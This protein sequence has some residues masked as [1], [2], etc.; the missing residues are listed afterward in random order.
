M[1]RLLTPPGIILLTTLLSFGFWIFPD[2]GILRKGFKPIIPSFSIGFFVAVLWYSIAMVSSLLG[3]HLGRKIKADSLIF[4][5]VADLKSDVPYYVLSF[6]S[7]LG[8]IATFFVIYTSAGNSLNQ[9]WIWVS[10]GNANKLKQALYEDYNVGILSLRYAAIH[11]A[12]MALVRRFIH[13]KKRKIDIINIMSLIWIALIS[14]RLAVIAC[15]LAFFIFYNA[16]RKINLG[17]K[18]SILL[19]VIGFHILSIFNYTRNINFYRQFGMGFYSAGFSE[20][21]TYVGSPFQG[22][23]SVAENYRFIKSNPSGWNFYAGIEPALST[24]SSFLEL[25]VLYGWN[26]FLFSSI[27]LFFLAL[28]AGIFEKFKSN[29]MYLVFTAL[30]Y[31]FAEFWRIFLFNKGILLTLVAV[32]FIVCTISFLLRLMPIWKK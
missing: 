19:I 28:I 8:V 32:P 30:M 16:Y 4:D 7:A 22:A 27:G 14:T 11:S 23:I 6:I 1:K 24:N 15:A 12:C 21:V 29:Y 26:C 18:R 31:G 9:I 25:F 10:S 13:K 17:L 3:F 5:K 20:I 2:F